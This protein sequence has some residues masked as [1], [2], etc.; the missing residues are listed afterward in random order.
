MLQLI[1]A[2]GGAGLRTAL[3]LL[4]A[5]VALVPPSVG[6]ALGGGASPGS[7]LLA[8]A[9]ARNA[10]DEVLAIAAAAGASY[11]RAAHGAAAMHAAVG[12][13]AAEVVEALLV[14]DL[15]DRG[16]DC[17]SPDD[18]GALVTA[19]SALVLSAPPCAIPTKLGA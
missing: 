4:E 2:L 17:V 19:A 15:V 7:R 10:P 13:G 18:G 6:L 5:A 11:S 1:S 9:A 14:H 12:A 8:A 3:A 16:A